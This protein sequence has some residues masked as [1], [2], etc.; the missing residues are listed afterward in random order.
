MKSLK[1]IAMI[2]IYKKLEGSKIKMPE[3]K[4]ERLL[5]MHKTNMQDIKLPESFIDYKDSIKSI[6]NKV[7]DLY[8]VCYITIDEKIV[9]NSTHRRGGRHVDF[10][11][12][13]NLKTHSDQGGH[14]RKMQGGYRASGNW[15]EPKPG[16]K[17][18][19]QEAGG[20]GLLLVSNYS[21]CKVW[22]GEF[23]G[24]IG[25]GGDCSNIDLNN[26]ESEIMPAGEVYYLN[27][28]G[29]HESLVIPTNVK[30]SLIRIN[31]HPQ[32]KF[33]QS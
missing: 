22:K 7:E 27:A 16:W 30:R 21:A 14:P 2:S 10:N 6:L 20:G 28:L 24:E 1:Q 9:N 5:Y 32:Y 23:D 18:E 31:F 33:N 13:E 4:K 11:W 25:D 15:D 26:L 3:F 19:L 8:N 12:D 17:T 29:I